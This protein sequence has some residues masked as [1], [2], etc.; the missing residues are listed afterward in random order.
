[1]NKTGTP[2]YTR[3]NRKGGAIQFKYIKRSLS[4]QNTTRGTIYEVSSGKN[5]YVPKILRNPHTT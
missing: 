1:M 2:K 3:D 5:S 4:L